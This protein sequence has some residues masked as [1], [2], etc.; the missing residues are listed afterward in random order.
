MHSLVTGGLVAG[1][2]LA[3]A[4]P[5]GLDHMARDPAACAAWQRQY[6]NACTVPAGKLARHDDA[7]VYDARRVLNA[8]CDAITRRAATACSSS[9]P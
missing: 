3:L 4:T 1:V 2:L 5:A 8:G 6:Q 9:Q 7:A